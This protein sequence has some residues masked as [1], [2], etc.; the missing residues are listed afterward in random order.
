MAETIVAIIPLYNG[1][2]Y[3]RPAIESILAQERQPD[4]IVV[5]DDGSTDNGE[6]AAVVSELNNPRIKLLFK[7]NGGQ[8]SA[9]NFG[10]QNSTSSLIAF[11]DQDDLWYPHHLRLL[12]KP[13]L[14]NK[15]PQL[16]WVYSNLDQI[17]A[18]GSMVCHSLLST[19]RPNEHPK[20]TIN[21]CLGQDM[22]ILPGASLIS[23]TAYESVG[24]FDPQ[25]TGYEDDDLFLR[26][27]CKGWRNEYIDKPL[28]IWRV[29]AESSS[30]SRRMAISRAKYFEKLVQA[31]PNNPDMNRYYVSE[32]IA[33][34]FVSNVL[35]DLY[36]GIKRK[37]PAK[38]DLARE[39]L[40]TF[41]RALPISRRLKVRAI[42]LAAT[43][44]PVRWML[45]LL[46]RSIVMGARPG[47]NFERD[48]EMTSILRHSQIAANSSC[49]RRRVYLRMLGDLSR[50]IDVLSDLFILRGI[51]GPYP[52]RQRV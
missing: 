43:L 6:G 8:G 11:L 18:D 38:I 44:P 29:H 42:A 17:S 20:R 2:K 28:T 31:F 16:G 47:S 21:C 50:R 7:E 5:V 4:E 26:M 22:Y 15:S 27:F 48:N 32:F 24:G 33:P 46:P 23:R 51:Q 52:I 3:I 41:S 36:T 35:L 49:Q 10:V 37:D 9:R 13:F 39:H 30:Y 14:K 34:R 12:E 45:R 25:F 1:A 40:K 19:L